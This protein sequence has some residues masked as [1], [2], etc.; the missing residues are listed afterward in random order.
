MSS[1]DDGPLILHY[2]Q[3]RARAEPLRMMMLHAGIPYEDKLYSVEDW[4]TAKQTMP[5]GKG[6]PGIASR[7]PG[8]RGLPVLELPSGERVVETADIARF[9]AEK[10]GAPLMPSDEGKAAEAQDM[11]E[12]T[13]GF[14]FYWPQP[15]MSSYPQEVSEAI[16]RGEKPEGTIH[17]NIADLPFSFAEVLPAFQAWEAR[18]AGDFY[19]G[20]VPHYGDFAL[21]HN[22]DAYRGLDRE[23][24]SAL[25]SLN[26]W[27]ERIEALPAVAK[28]LAERPRPGHSAD[29]VNGAGSALVCG[30]VG[31]IYQKWADPANRGDR[32]ASLS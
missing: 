7:P 18:L 14:P 23:A 29:I 11:W 5:A 15:M 3:L 19:G 25:T 6:V 27:A 31:T 16:L 8:N 21:Y 12:T 28:Y 9:I 2:F 24:A 26:Q 10:A 4:K 13:M 20:E 30:R 1:T 32:G 17:G 22:F